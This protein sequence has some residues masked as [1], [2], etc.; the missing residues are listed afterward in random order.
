MYNLFKAIKRAAFINL[1]Q[2]ENGI[3]MPEGF[4]LSEVCTPPRPVNE[5]DPEGRMINRP[6]TLNELLLYRR[7]DLSGYI[8]K[9]VDTETL[10]AVN[11]LGALENKLINQ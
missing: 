1:Y 6:H 3:R 11:R 8:S 2:E 10:R 5:T 9:P 7:L 4:R